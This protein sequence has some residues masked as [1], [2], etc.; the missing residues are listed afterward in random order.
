[1]VGSTLNRKLLRDLNDH[2]IALV[3]L[4]AI[5]AVGICVFV[6]TI[7]SYRGLDDARA[8][9]YDRYRISDFIIN[10]KRAPA[11]TVDDVAALPNVRDVRGRVYLATRVSLGSVAE[12]ISGVALSVPAVR[13]PIVN[14]VLLRSGTWFSGSHAKEVILNE[15][16]A[17]KHDLK[18]GDTLDVLLLDK[19]HH[20]LVVGTAMSPEY[21]YVIPP[22]GGIVP[23][24]ARFAV[25]YLPE[26]F[27][28]DSCNL[29]GAYNQIVGRA[30]DTSRPAVN[31]TLR[32]I[33]RRL[34]PYGVTDAS[35]YWEQ[36]SVRFVADEIQGRK[37]GAWMM[38]VLF[39]GVAALVL[40][41]LMS[42]M[43]QQ[44][45]SIIGTLRALGYSRWAIMRHYL[46][47]GVVIGVVGAII[48]VAGGW[49]LQ[50]LI[51]GIDREMYRMP[52]LEAPFYWSTALAGLGVSVFFAVLGTWAG[53]RRAAR[54][55]PA[56][57]MRPPPP[58]KGARVL[59]ERWAAFWRMLSFRSKMIMRAIFRNPFR[60]SVGVA[61]TLISTALV[62]ST[63]A[64]FD[65][66]DY[67]LAFQFKRIQHEDYSVSLRDPKGRRAISELTAMPGVTDVEAQ[68]T[69]VCDLSN[70]PATKRIGVTGIR[71]DSRLYTPLDRTGAPIAVPESGLLLDRKLAE[72]LHVAPGDPIRLRPLIG[73]RRETV[74]LVVGTV[75][76]FLGLAAYAD[77][78]TLSRLVGEEWSA[79]VLLSRAENKKRAGPFMDDLKQRPAVVGLGE[80]SRSF[81]QIDE[82]FGEVMGTQLFIM[83]VFAGLIAFGSVLNAAMVSLS[84]RRRE[85]GTLRVLGYTPGQ[86]GSIFSGESWLVNV[87]GIALG[88]AGGI[89]LTHL[90]A[91]AYDTELYRFP[92][93]IHPSRLVVTV[94]VMIVFI[95]AAHWIVGRMIRR[96]PWLEVL[97]IKE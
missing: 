28:Q 36:A 61:A 95:A 49:W 82:Q 16:F 84:E 53:V 65:A 17:A 27:A 79:N 97:S 34:D 55:E 23:D 39:L 30:R 83:I 4:L 29:A 80:R 60:S 92:V 41:V 88:L 58:E 56:E 68:L 74:T 12:P 7:G 93:V 14:D 18:P 71:R 8:A 3:A 22:A 32:T 35:P 19:E 64:L 51:N 96:L 33:E 85:V 89:G 6:G 10:L 63:L 86:V 42:R 90:L 77:I 20:L 73:E 66:L 91:K 25:L 59:P 15:A 9:Y 44:Q 2:K 13:H 11:W 75:D 31:E 76:S 48:G 26:G 21:V 62:L 38:P 54:L 78:N 37:V 50:V 46:A 45:R 94:V 5:I 69:V 47:F 52:N 67:M 81:S 57:A 43:V 40:N 72:V 70:G 24:A 87:V 1:M